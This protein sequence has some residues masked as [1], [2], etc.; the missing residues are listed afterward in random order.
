MIESACES[1]IPIQRLTAQMA[2]KGDF[3]DLNKK[4][5]RGEWITA[6]RLH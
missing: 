6:T 1:D 4:P 2:M 3:G 5:D